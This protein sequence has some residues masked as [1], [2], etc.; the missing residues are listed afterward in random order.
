MPDCAA[1]RAPSDPATLVARVG[2]EVIRHVGHA[3]DDDVASSSSTA[4]AIRTD[5]RP[6]CGCYSRGRR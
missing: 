1:V 3:P 6:R 2:D 4:T 5:H